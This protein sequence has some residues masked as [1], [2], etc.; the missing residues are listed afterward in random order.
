MTL[1]TPGRKAKEQSQSNCDKLVAFLQE[2]GEA[3]TRT[4]KDSLGL[5]NLNT[6]QLFT[7]NDLLRKQG[8]PFRLRT[9]PVGSQ[10]ELHWSLKQRV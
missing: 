1:G 7:F 8:K 9:R 3:G 10:R 6:C 2:H 4:I 5:S